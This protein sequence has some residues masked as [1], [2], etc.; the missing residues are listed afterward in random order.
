MSDSLRYKILLGSVWVQIA[1]LPVWLC[2]PHMSASQI[3][4][5]IEMKGFGAEIFI[6]SWFGS[7]ILHISGEGEIYVIAI[8]DVVLVFLL[9]YLIQIFI[10]SQF[11]RK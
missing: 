4:T 9:V 11:Y 5:W 3:T 1:L 10:N 7:A 8:F 6:R 2:M